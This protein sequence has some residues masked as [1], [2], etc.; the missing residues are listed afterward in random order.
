[1]IVLLDSCNPHWVFSI[2]S[3]EL[4]IWA[5]T[6]TLTSKTANQPFHMTL[7]LIIMH[8][9]TK[10][11]DKRF[12]TY[13]TD[14]YSLTFWSFAQSYVDYISPHCDFDLED[15]K[16]I[17]RMTLWFMHDNTLEYQVWS[18]RVEQFRRYPDIIWTH[19]KT[20]TWL[21]RQTETVV[22]TYPCFTLLQGGG[23]NKTIKS[24]P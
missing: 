20:D 19:R 21:H 5:F 9:H 16:P 11:G 15:S 22:P 7:W 24:L 8:N 18:Q 4:I 13:C 10:F 1:M 2:N 3:L 6:V 17:F 23:I 14:K 12:S